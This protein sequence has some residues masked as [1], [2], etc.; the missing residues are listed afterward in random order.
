M[1]HLGERARD[2]ERAAL[3]FL[4]WPAS[5]DEKEH[6]V[7][8]IPLG[9]SELPIQGFLFLCGFSASII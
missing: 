8:Y 2:A 1:F 5:A 4:R 9:K 3:V 7:S 6:V